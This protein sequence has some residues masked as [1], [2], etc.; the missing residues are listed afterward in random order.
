VDAKQSH[1]GLPR[2]R[3]DDARSPVATLSNVTFVAQAFHQHVP[4]TA[5]ALDT[6]SGLRG[7][8]RKAV[9]RQG[10]DHHVEGVFGPAAER[11]RIGERADDLDLLEDRAGPAVGDDQ[12]HRVRMARADVDEVDVDAVDGRLELR[13]GI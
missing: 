9:T 11:G 6:P 5:D 8:R 13:Q 7:P 4:R 12:R 10:R 2:H 1:R 3:L